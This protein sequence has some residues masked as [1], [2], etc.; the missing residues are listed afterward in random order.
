VLSGVS[1]THPAAHA[2]AEEWQVPSIIQKISSFSARLLRRDNTLGGVAQPSAAAAAQAL[3]PS[4]SRLNPESSLL[5]YTPSALPP[6]PW[7]VFAPHADDETYGMGGALLL[8]KAQKIE[9]HVVVLTDGALGGEAEGL[10]ALRQAEVQSAAREL[11]LA[12]L[13]CWDEPDRGLTVSEALIDKLCAQIKQVQPAAVFFPGPLEAH[14][15]HRIT[16]QLAW[17]ALQKIEVQ[18]QQNAMHDTAEAT[19]SET[20]Q[21]P[22]AFSYEISNQ[23]PINIMLDTT[24]VIEAKA[25]VMSCYDSQ[26]SEN[27]YED[28]VLALDK[29]RTFTMPREVLHC[30]G[31]YHYSPAQRAQPLQTVTQEIISKYF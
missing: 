6:G 10:V 4:S 11:G 8:A 15:D 23:N 20:A 3:E 14:P 24:E 16:A 22:Q 28:L 1:V 9:T 12:S 17:R 26:N 7:L 30:E 19:R 5:P 31:F 13:V 29:G 27:N 21:S 18:Q 25:R 2:A